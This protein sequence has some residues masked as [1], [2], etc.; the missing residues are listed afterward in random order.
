MQWEGEG[1]LDLRFPA[2]SP[3]GFAGTLSRRTGKGF[4]PYEV[5]PPSKTI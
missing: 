5:G 1:A 4:F 2:P 3:T